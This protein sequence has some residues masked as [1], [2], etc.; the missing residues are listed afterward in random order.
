MRFKS[1]ERNLQRCTALC[2]AVQ[3]FVLKRNGE[4]IARQGETCS[5]V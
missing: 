4:A 2:R 3:S 1:C 5:C